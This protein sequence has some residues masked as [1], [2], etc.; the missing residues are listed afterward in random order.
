MKSTIRFIGGVLSVSILTLSTVIQ[1]SAAIVTPLATVQTTLT[2]VEKAQID[3]AFSNRLDRQDNDTM[4]EKLEQ[5]RVKLA[6]ALIT[7]Q[8]NSFLL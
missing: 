6:L 7:Y 2:T 8:R 5:L 4:D 1:V 3:L